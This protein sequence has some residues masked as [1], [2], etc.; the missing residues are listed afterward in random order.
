M[1]IFKLVST[2]KIEDNGL[3]NVCLKPD[4]NL[5]NE[6]IA[7]YRTYESLSEAESSL[8]SFILEMTPLLFNDFKNMDNISLE[9]RNLFIL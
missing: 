4:N 1:E 5:I 8:N 9:L 3:V 6:Y 2:M 7:T